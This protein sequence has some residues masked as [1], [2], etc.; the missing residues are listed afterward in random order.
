MFEK[1]YHATH[2]DMMDGA[3]NDDLRERYL[4]SGLFQP[5]KVTLNYCHNERMVVGGAAPVTQAIELPAQ[6]EPASAK[7][8]PFLERR[9]IG[10]INIGDG[11]GVIEVDGVSHD[12]GAARR[13]LHSDG[14]GEG[15]VQVEGRREARALLSR[16]DAGACAL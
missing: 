6:T 3:S 7:G 2:P 10:A 1:T 14:L 11:P 16:L 9:E 8:K 13:A 12:L 4:I 15:G 5:D